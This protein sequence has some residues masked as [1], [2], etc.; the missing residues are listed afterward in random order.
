M[1]PATDTLRELILPNYGILTKASHS[2]I[3]SREIPLPSEPRTSTTCERGDAMRTQ[4]IQKAASIDVKKPRKLG[5]YLNPQGYYSPAWAGFSTNSVRS[6]LKKFPNARRCHEDTRN[7]KSCI[8]RCQKASQARIIFINPQGYYSPAW[9]GLLV[10]SPPSG[11]FWPTAISH[12][13]H[14]CSP[15]PS[16]LR[17]HGVKE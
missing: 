17:S 6:F 11:S 2:F 12:E 15:Q 4:G 16:I 10:T 14:V 8:Y 9:D 7:S 5:F 1:P 13:G 3:T